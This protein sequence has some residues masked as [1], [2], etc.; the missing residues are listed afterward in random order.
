MTTQTKEIELTVRCSP[1]SSDGAGEHRVL[2]KL[3][4][5]PSVLVW[6]PIARF[7]TVCHALSARTEARIV[8]RARLEVQS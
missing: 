2:V 7:Y 1:W 3:G 8:R 6:D 5:Q 4:A